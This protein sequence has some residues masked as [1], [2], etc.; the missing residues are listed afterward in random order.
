M[1]GQKINR[2]EALAGDGGRFAFGLSSDGAQ[3]IFLGKNA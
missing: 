1:F 2:L 3:H